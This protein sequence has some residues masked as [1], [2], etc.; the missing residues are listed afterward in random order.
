ADLAESLLEGF[1]QGTVH[2]PEPFHVDYPCTGCSRMCEVRSTE[3]IWL[4]KSRCVDCGGAWP[5]GAGSMPSSVLAI[6]VPGDLAA[7][8]PLAQLPMSDLGVKPGGAVLYDSATMGKGLLS[9]A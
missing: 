6:N 1:G 4:A 7:G 3:S 5:R 8:S 9:F 2:L